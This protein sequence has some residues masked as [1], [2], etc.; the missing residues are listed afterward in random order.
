MVSVLH[1][2]QLPW[3]LRRVLCR[4]PITAG[5]LLVVVTLDIFQCHTNST[6]SLYHFA[7]NNRVS[8]DI[9]L[10]R[11]LQLADMWLTPSC[12]SFGLLG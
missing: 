7:K 3:K 11:T 6:S 2:T 8:L 10:L 1:L 4:R 9:L 12:G 5:S